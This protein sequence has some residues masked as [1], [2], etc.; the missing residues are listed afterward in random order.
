MG[1]AD[2]KRFLSWLSQLDEA[3]PVVPP[4][5]NQPSAR[6]IFEGVPIEKQTLDKALTS[7]K[8]PPRAQDLQ[9]TRLGLEDFEQPII[10]T[11]PATRGTGSGI[12][13]IERNG[14]ERLPRAK[15]KEDRYEYKSKGSRVK[16]D[17]GAAAPKKK[18]SRQK[19]KHT[20]NE[21]FRASN[22]P[23]NRLT[24]HSATNLGIFNK[25]RRS[26]PV[27][28]R[29][30]D[31]GFSET[32]FLSKMPTHEQTSQLRRQKDNL[33]DYFDFGNET[34]Q[35]FQSHN[36]RDS[37]TSRPG[38][39]ERSQH[40]LDLGQND[41]EVYH[42]DD[43]ASKADTVIVPF[44][45]HCSRG[46]ERNTTARHIVC[47]QAEQETRAAARDVS[48]QLLDFDLYSPDDSMSISPAKKYWTLEELKALMQRRISAWGQEDD[49]CT[50]TQ[51]QPQRLSRKR[52]H[53]SPPG[54]ETTSTQWS[55]QKV[56]RGHSQ[57]LKISPTDSSTSSQAAILY[58]FSNPRMYTQYSPGSPL[59]IHR[60]SG[61]TMADDKV[62]PQRPFQNEGISAFDDEDTLLVSQ[63]FDAA[64]EAI[65]QPERDASLDLPMLS[66]PKRNE[67]VGNDQQNTDQGLQTAW[68]WGLEDAI[69]DPSHVEPDMLLTYKED[70]NRAFSTT[71]TGN[72]RQ[73]SPYVSGLCPNRTAL[74]PIQEN[75]TWRASGIN[76]SE[77]D[78]L[79]LGPL[80]NF[81]RQNK[82]Y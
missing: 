63:A 65:M 55:R 58:P 56:A 28:T 45:Q 82:L 9:Q 46:K 62:P 53:T 60:Y 43:P 35:P 72:L 76:G 31:Q 32:E 14:Y 27:K 19:R 10:P 44:S 50:T 71:W 68:E 81:W 30:L 34:G 23:P 80:K 38:A 2:Q 69:L 49:G 16:S 25:G 79:D 54:N 47:S 1:I 17:R 7:Q 48:L 57:Q 66:S 73:Q 11:R 20:I 42:N 12:T 5:D 6:F 21:D 4:G 24:L 36:R 13:R 51:T 67:T 77:R 33:L 61:H 70:Q 22:V 59:A 15:T 74:R 40:Q 75:F 26:S 37:E 39:K 3:E 52:K 41:N 29:V 78:I 64:Y 18:S 8:R